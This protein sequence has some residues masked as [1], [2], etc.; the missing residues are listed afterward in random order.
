[1]PKLALLGGP[2]VHE[3]GWPEWPMVT[4]SDVERVAAV[5]RSGLWGLGG[6]AIDE[7]QN[8]WAE[9]CGAKHCVCVNCGTAA[10]E[11]ALRSV[12][13]G[14]GDEVIIPAYTFIATA[15]AV[16]HVGA[17]PVF[18]DIDPDS[19]LLD[20]KAVAEA[21]T[22]KTKA[23]IPV[24]IGGSPCDMDAFNALA[25]EHGLFVIEDAA[26]AHG[27]IYKGRK[28]GALGHAGCFSFQSSKNL[29]GGEGGAVCTND[30]PVGEVAWS[31]HNCGR[32]RPGARF[33]EDRLG[34]NMRMSQFTAA[35]LLGGLE[36]LEE[37]SGQRAA[38][39]AH[40]DRRLSDIPGITPAGLAPGGERSAYHMYMMKYDERGFDGLPR[41]RFAGAV[42]AEGIPLC[43]GY[44]PLYRTLASLRDC[45]PDQCPLACKFHG[46]EMDYSQVELPVTEQVCAQSLWLPQ[47]V[48]LGT[49]QDM[50]DIA[51][52]MLKVRENVGELKQAAGRN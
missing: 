32:T 15:S 20:P 47:N 42:Q 51:A 50:D 9:Y 38:N 34:H 22:G 36:R 39:A 8:R 44:A 40:L 17:V 12:G 10:L 7:F 29:S 45:Q 43:G 13:V 14:A 46:R 26:Q 37:Q 16:I 30:D 49:Q 23:I 3:G 18:A 19:F 11:L 4:E 25:R 35:I 5:A 27:A 21:L 41:D 31:L 2:K 6:T 28:V 33:E 1:M 24:H 52:A 48:L